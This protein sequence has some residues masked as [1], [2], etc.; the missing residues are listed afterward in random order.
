M[1]QR[2]DARDP[3]FAAAFDAILVAKR[4]AAAD[5]DAATAAIVDTVRSAG[6]AA[7]LDYTCRFDG[8]DLRADQ[9]RID[10][11]EVQRA[12]AACAPETLAALAFAADRITAFHARQKPT[13]L[14]YTDEQG[15][16]SVIAGHQSMRPASMCQVGP[17]PIPPR[18]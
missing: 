1:P 12:E 6:D 16:V 13:D 2:L 14:D 15:F 11:A 18:C 3:G 4:E 7:V 17:P 9:L 10:A 8:L 5:V